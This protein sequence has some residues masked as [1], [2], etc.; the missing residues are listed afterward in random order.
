MNAHTRSP[1]GWH[2]NL[3]FRMSSPPSGAGRKFQRL[4][5]IMAQLRG[6][7]G[8]PWDREQNFDA[9]KRYTLE[10]SYEVIDAIDRRAWADL[11]DELGD[12]I[13]QAVFYAQ[14]ASEQELFNI[15]DSLDAI[16]EK[17]IRRHPHVFGGAQA[18]TAGEVLQ[19]WDEIKAGERKQRG[20]AR[21][22]LLDS[23]SRA[24]PALM[25]AL[26]IASKAAKAGFDWENVDQVFEKMR[27]ELDELA[28]ARASASQSDIEDEIGDL[29]FVIVNIA[30]FLKI[31]PEQAL[32]KTNA[33]FRRR[34]AYLEERLRE[35]GKTPADSSIEEMEA[36]WQQAKQPT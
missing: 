4:V 16:N 22:N 8:C 17:L 26:E 28:G 34:F 23:V 11:A 13:L 29:L 12:Y 24:Q 9:I 36:L 7:N 15:E 21:Q 6:P 3:N 30:R 5:E 18:E 25:E 1:A 33:K 27:E 10:E 31:D 35:R 14:M 2:V 19:R 32:R 20:I